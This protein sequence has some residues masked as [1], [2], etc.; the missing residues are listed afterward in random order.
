MD[1]ASVNILIHTRREA[2]RK[3][4]LSMRRDFEC[5]AEL[6]E[7]RGLSIDLISSRV[8]NLF[9]LGL[10]AEGSGVFGIWSQT[11]NATFR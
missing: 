9:L 6:K 8:A 5:K 7:F 10:F 11:G 3:N 4:T 2:S 1:T